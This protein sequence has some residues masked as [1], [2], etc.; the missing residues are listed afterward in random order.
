MCIHLF[1]SNWLEPIGL[2]D[3][4]GVTHKQWCERLYM[5]LKW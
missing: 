2:E 1:L 5:T 4:A 3:L